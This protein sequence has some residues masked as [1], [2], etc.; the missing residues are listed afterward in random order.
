M[1]DAPEDPAVGPVVLG[2]VAD[3]R[4]ALV[5]RRRPLTPRQA[6]ALELEQRL[7]VPPSVVRRVAAAT[8]PSLAAG[9]R[10]T[11]VLELRQVAAVV[12]PLRPVPAVVGGTVAD[13][14]LVDLDVLGDAVVDLRHREPIRMARM[15][16]A[17]PP[18]MAVDLA[19]RWVTSTVDATLVVGWLLVARLAADDV[20]T[21]S[22]GA[23]FLAAI[24]NE[25][26]GADRGRRA[27]L[28]AALLSLG[29]TTKTLHERAVLVAERSELLDVAVA[30][31]DP[32][33][34]DHLLP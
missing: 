6:T 22:E 2:T 19:L 12:C 29:S 8:D 31:R 15:A 28:G 32:R 18:E 24:A 5:A 17:A 9:L 1:D 34:M 10:A 13:E 33:L 14:E 16:S 3:V 25:V 30:L 4:D 7:G 21:P 27:V 20:L 23:G 11:G 26:P